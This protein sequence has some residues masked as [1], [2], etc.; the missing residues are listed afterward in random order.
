MTLPK[1]PS[2]LTLILL[3]A[4]SVLSLNLFLPSLSRIAAEFEADYALV[5]LSIGGYL[6]VSAVLQV[7]MG[8]LSDMYGR[9]PVLLAGLGIFIV[10]SIGC[11][12]AQDIWVFLGFRLLQS[13][14]V[15]AMVISRAVV[16]DIAPAD[17]AARL[18]GLIGTAMALAPLLG[19]V[20]GGVLD[21]LFGWRA[22]FAAFVLMGVGLFALTWVD[23]PETNTMRN[24]SFTAQFRSYPELLGVP[25]FWAHCGALVFSV[26]GFYAFLGGAPQ[27]AE[28]Q[29]G[30]TP[31][32]VG[33]G[34]GSISAGFMLG[35]YL[36]GRLSGRV[37][38]SR[39]VLA[40]RWLALIGP[41]IGVALFA[42]GADSALLMFGCVMFIGLGNGLTIPGVNASVM[43]VAP[44]LA[45]SASGLS[46]ALTL[47]GGAAL[48][49]ISGLVVGGTGGA[50][51][52][53]SLLVVVSALALISAS[54]AYRI[55]AR[56]ALG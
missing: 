1:K 56:M 28:A 32:L 38:L 45:G 35:N 43:S 24:P 6:A 23:L 21:Q 26:G 25:L 10:A 34:M 31:A 36:T 14:V 39:I 41:G 42:L 54:Y 52:L 19:P 2:L 55:E 51:A 12:L 29:F 11:L 46:G 33:V 49:A 5:S 8:P 18:L 20:L 50:A 47:G 15:C 48:T 37:A 17:Q 40:G 22:S 16:R 13:T 9:R 30:M 53:L 7:I 3:T 44:H 4:I 27:V